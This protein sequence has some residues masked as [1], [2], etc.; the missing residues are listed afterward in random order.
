ME[1]EL[2][3]YKA[4]LD[5]IVFEDRNKS[6]G[7][8]FLRVLY[9]I[10][11]T[12]ATIITCASF[13]LLMAG[14]N[15]YLTITAKPVEAYVPVEIKMDITDEPLKDEE[16]K[17]LPPPPPKV[18]QPKIEQ[19][20]FLPPVIKPDNKVVKEE[21]MKELDS[22]LN[23]NISNKNVEGEKGKIDPFANDGDENGKL[24]GTGEKEAEV[25]LFAGEMPKFKG[26]GDEEV[27]KYVQ[28]R[29]IYP[30][31]AKNKK[32]EGTVFVQYTITATGEVTNVHIVPGRG[33]DASIDAEA[34][35]VIKGMPK[36][37][38]G[39]NNGTPVAVKKVARIKFS[40]N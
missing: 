39:K 31:D 22:L 28:G 20:K 4:T 38:P 10:N 30:A 13:I 27:I 16:I 2:D 1:K 15:F 29:L 14:I 23:T 33:L 17:K 18:E 40:L 35:R 26:G 8:Y 25:F 21:Q 32:I 7:G 3:L 24:G 34:V 36:W 19:V 11:V 9:D 12:K 37:E 5:E 6:Y